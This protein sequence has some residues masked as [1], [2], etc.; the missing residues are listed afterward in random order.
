MSA[1]QEADEAEVAQN[2]FSEHDQDVDGTSSAF[3]S[4][5]VIDVPSKKRDPAAVLPASLLA[6]KVLSFLS[7]EAVARRITLLNSTWYQIAEH[8]ILW[9]FYCWQAVKRN[10]RHQRTWNHYWKQ[11]VKKQRM[12][13]IDAFRQLPRVRYDGVFAQRT[14]YIRPGYF[15]I[16]HPSG[17]NA[18]NIVYHRLFLFKKDGTLW[19]LMVPGELEHGMRALR[20]LEQKVYWHRLSSL[21]SERDLKM[22]AYNRLMDLLRYAHQ[23]QMKMVFG[24]DISLFSLSNGKEED[25]AEESGYG[26]NKPLAA[27]SRTRSVDNAPTTGTVPEAVPARPP[28]LP[29]TSTSVVGT[30][31]STPIPSSNRSDR[32]APLKGTTFRR[33]ESEDSGPNSND[34]QTDNLHP[35][36]P[37]LSESAL[38]LGVWEMRGPTVLATTEV[39]NSTRSICRWKFRVCHEGGVSSNRLEVVSQTLTHVDAV[40]AD[41]GT[42]G[43]SFRGELMRFYSRQSV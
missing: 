22:E 42:V 11:V 20:K 34:P 29:D 39:R 28:G 6:A 13:W 30:P 24:E 36:I 23:R 19:H 21:T 15:D 1:A 43:E 8:P 35:S 3:A 10:I 33:L 37:E 16:W 14:S 41:G 18:H 25:E 5:L 26:Q 12:R 4:S 38:S 9:E 27:D 40:S 2:A 17:R 32:P 31:V 7:P